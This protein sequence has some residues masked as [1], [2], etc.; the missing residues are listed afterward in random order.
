MTSINGNNNGTIVQLEANG[1]HHIQASSSSSSQHHPVSML[2]SGT[3]NVAR[4]GSPSL[5][6]N[7]SQIH[8]S[9]IILNDN[10]N[11]VTAHNH[12][13]NHHQPNL[14]QINGTSRLLSSGANADQ[15]GNTTTPITFVAYRQQRT[16]SGSSFLTNN[17]TDNNSTAKLVTNNPLRSSA[18][19]SI[20]VNMEIPNDLME[21]S[22]NTLFALTNTKN[23]VMTPIFASTVNGGSIL[24]NSSTIVGHQ[25]PEATSTAASSPIDNDI[26]MAVNEMDEM[27][28]LTSSFNFGK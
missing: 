15:N 7:M 28:T 26:T 27:D 17:D 10:T 3:L 4:Q 25:R 22:S 20:S 23:S 6:L 1:E 21:A 8:S 5:I 19:S 16:I 13:V 24:A 14:L 9:F 2:H 12:N 11:N 18:S